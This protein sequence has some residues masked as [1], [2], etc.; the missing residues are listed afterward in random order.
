MDFK[1]FDAVNKSEPLDVSDGSS[2]EDSSTCIGVSREGS[3]SPLPAFPEETINQ[4]EPVEAEHQ[5]SDEDEDGDEE[6]NM[7][8][9]HDT[10]TE[11]NDTIMLSVEDVD[12][13]KPME[14]NSK[15]KR[16]TQAVTKSWSRTGTSQSMDV[17][18]DTNTQIFFASRAAFWVMVAAHGLPSACGPPVGM[19]EL[20][21]EMGGAWRCVS[22]PVLLSDT[23]FSFP[24]LRSNIRLTGQLTEP[25]FIQR[26]CMYLD[27]EVWYV[28]QLRSCP[29]CVFPYEPYKRRDIMPGGPFGCFRR[30]STGIAMPAWL[31]KHWR[32]C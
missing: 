20:G 1:S 2:T 25:V 8:T 17:D 3:Y 24:C 13:S 21:E 16:P 7:N 4:A 27:G 32:N 18:E 26:K 9:D 22:D 31:G 11:L 6:M 30:S 23:L 10:A 5:D 15:H 19:F 12:P 29:R 28:K 14:S